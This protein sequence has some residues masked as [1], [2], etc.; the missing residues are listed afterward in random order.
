MADIYKSMCEGTVNFNCTYDP[1]EDFKCFNC[2]E[3]KCKLNEVCV[4]N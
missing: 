4:W 1:P 2:A 3:M